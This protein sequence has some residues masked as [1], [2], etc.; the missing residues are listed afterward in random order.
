MNINIYNKLPLDIKEKIDIIINNKIKNYYRYTLIYDIYY[1]FSKNIKTKK[2]V[3]TSV[4]IREKYI[5]VKA[6]QHS[7]FNS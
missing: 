4:T 1:Y 2:V 6:L 3:Q 7:L 5:S